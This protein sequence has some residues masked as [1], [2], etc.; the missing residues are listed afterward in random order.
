MVAD[1]RPAEALLRVADERDARMIVVGTHGRHP[2]KGA[3]PA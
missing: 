3:V 1:A 2:L